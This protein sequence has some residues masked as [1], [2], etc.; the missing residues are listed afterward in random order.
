MCYYIKGF[1]KGTKIQAFHIRYRGTG[2]IKRQNMRIL[3]IHRMFTLRFLLYA[4]LVGIATAEHVRSPGMF[5]KRLLTNE[6]H[7]ADPS[8]PILVGGVSIDNGAVYALGETSV[9]SRLNVTE[10]Y[11]NGQRLVPN[12]SLL[13]GGPTVIRKRYETKT[14]RSALNG[15]WDTDLETTL[16][17]TRVGKMVTMS[18]TQAMGTASC[19]TND[20]VVLEAGTIPASFRATDSTP[21]VMHSF[22]KDDGVVVPARTVL[23]ADG[24]VKWGRFSCSGESGLFSSSITYNCLSG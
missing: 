10:I 15:I 8:K 17:L 16:T 4:W 2:L 9:L 23:F 13:T 1:R 21:V 19:G 18:W 6:I 5:T 24:S 14:F 11:L 3:E 22:V 7:S 12:D 20:F